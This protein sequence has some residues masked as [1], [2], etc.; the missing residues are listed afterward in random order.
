MNVPLDGRAFATPHVLCKDLGDDAILLDLETETYFGL[1]AAGSRLWNLL[2]TAP[3]I[4]DAFAAML[5]EYDVVPDELER[6]MSALI[7]DLVDRGL[8]RTGNA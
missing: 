7:A 2:T 1:N 4:R 6:D 3:T 5:E 8:L